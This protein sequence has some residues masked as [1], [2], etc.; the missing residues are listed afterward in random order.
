MKFKKI[1][2]LNLLIINYL[3]IGKAQTPMRDSVLTLQNFLQIVADNHPSVKQANLLT[4]TAQAELLAAKGGF[5]PKLY[6]DFEQKFFN[7]KTYFNV[8][9]GGLKV[10]TWYGIEAKSSYSYV[11]GNFINPSESI[12]SAGQG[13]IGISVPVLQGFMIDERRGNLFKARQSQQLNANE[14]TVLLNDLAFSATQIYW[15]WA[16]SVENRRIFQEALRLAEVRFSAT[17]IAFVQGD[18]M[19]MDTLESFIQVQDRQVQFNEANLD[20]QEANLKLANFLWNNQNKPLPFSETL[21]AENLNKTPLN[22]EG[23]QNRSILLQNVAE[24]HPILTMYAAK[25]AQLNVD[26]Q[27]KREK[28][29]PKL[30]LNYNIL[31]NALAFNSLFT[32]NYKW[33]VSFSTST[34]FRAERGD[35]ELTKIKI[36]NTNLLRDQKAL[37]LQN[38][39][40]L[41]FNEV[42]NLLTQLDLYTKTVN[43]YRQLLALENSRFQLGE[44]SLFLVNSREVK[45]IEAQ[46]KLAKLQAELNIAQTS[47]N[48]AAGRLG[49]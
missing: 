45:L 9:E 8:G 6:G 4:R 15:K 46:I 20:V 16:F 28:L 44:S 34:L 29:K 23:P 32:D 5:D 18:R 2:L 43:N 41:A 48:W 21:V 30:N 22:T 11:G 38:K 10:P 1:F 26:K 13:L 27:L 36:E 14:R 25:I 24:T 47:V 12:P 7:K 33:G 49:F 19:A 3:L 37:E 42:D 39:L 31:G 17:K 40:R 35:L